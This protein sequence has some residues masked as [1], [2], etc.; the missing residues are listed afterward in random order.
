MASVPVLVLL[1]RQLTCDP[2]FQVH[3]GLKR[4]TRT[5]KIID[6]NSDRNESRS[7]II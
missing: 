2:F 1:I 4:P 6:H 5:S 3:T 7:F